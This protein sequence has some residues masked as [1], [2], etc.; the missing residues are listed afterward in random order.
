MIAL[1]APVAGAQAE[2]GRLIEDFEALSAVRTTGGR[3][4]AIRAGEG[5][6]QGSQAAELPAGVRMDLTLRGVDLA[7]TPW[8]R[9]DTLTTQPQTH[10]LKLRFDAPGSPEHPAYLRAG[11]D[12]LW[13]PLTVAA[14]EMR[15]GWPA[16]AI[17]LSITNAAESSIVVDNA[18]LMPAAAPPQGAVLLDFGPDGQQL[19]PGFQRAGTDCKH[20]VWSGEVKIYSGR[21]GH[22]D[23]LTG[24]YVGPYPT[25]RAGDKFALA[26]PLGASGVA[27]LWVTHYGYRCFQA[28]EYS[29]VAGSRTVLQ[30]RQTPRQ[31]LGP[32]G[33]LLGMGGAWT[34]QWFAEEYARQFY[35]AVAV[36][37]GPRGN[38]VRVSNCQ[39]A[40]VAMAPAAQRLALEAYVK[41]VEAELTRFRR[42]FVVGYAA[43]DL[44]NCEPDEAEAKAGLMLFRPPPDMAFRAGWAPAKDDRAREIKLLAATGSLAV[45]PLAAAPVK[46]GEAMSASIAALSGASGALP[47]DRPGPAVWM[48]ER[49]PVVRS[50]RVLFQPWVLSRRLEA[51]RAGEVCHAVVVIPIALGAAAGTYRGAVRFTCSHGSAE[52]PLSL[53]VVD[54]GGRLK[55]PP[56]FLCE[57]P[58]NI[59]MFYHG[60]TD[61][62]AAG[63]ANVLTARLRQQFAEGTFNSLVLAGPSLGD[64]GVHEKRCEEDLSLT[65][66]RTLAGPVVLDM[67]PALA[68]L[69]FQGTAPGTLR[70]SS[71]VSAVTA[72]AAAL[73]ARHGVKDCLLL[74]G[75]AYSAETLDGE[76]RRCAAVAAAGGRAALAA[77]CG[78]LA[79]LAEADFAAKLRPVAALMLFDG[80]PAAEV[81]KRFRALG[82]Q[83]S[84]YLRVYRPD[85][86]VG[87]FRA[88]AVGADGTFALHVGMDGEPYMG[89]RLDGSGVL[90]PRADG[91]LA[92][93]M[94][95]LRLRQAREDFLLLRRAEQLVRDGGDGR[96][97][98]GL[99][100]ALQTV[101][102][103]A[104]DTSG[105]QF[106]AEM[107]RSTAVEPGQLDAWRQQLLRAAGPSPPPAADR[108]AASRQ[109]VGL[110]P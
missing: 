49:V 1:C 74:T 54:L 43:P 83:R 72:R 107:L 52:L 36:P 81:T 59:G 100:A 95:A 93:T 104:A 21:R 3:L 90:A 103:K 25:N 75:Y 85:R 26:A 64:D 82:G 47:T 23:P 55:E 13:V 41:Q 98:D 89:F 101:R 51:L 65:P 60:L 56:V 45:V 69:A 14:G 87:G 102:S 109:A 34:P 78:A 46:G 35:D 110:A 30:R 50:G 61:L 24:D 17:G 92:E 29:V 11:K 20:V 42:Q 97:L 22:P 79:R 94:A 77:D 27:W 19:W 33:L 7:A 99:R 105:G 28:A 91:S 37:L 53:E 67:R 80:G 96:R 57:E 86:Y 38:I 70:Y 8:L 9:L 48:L 108:P 84:V 66:L 58:V 12:V 106:S 5:V 18:R 31:M 71:A 4:L 40:A 2:E 76:A 32:T 10:C 63:Q 88:A 68:F 16:E 6:T 39:L 15:D 62:L 44:A 73:A